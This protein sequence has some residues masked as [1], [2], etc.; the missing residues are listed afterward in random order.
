VHVEDTGPGIPAERL[1]RIFEPFYSTKL[2]SGG[3]GLGLAISYDIVRRH[4]GS[5]GA[6][7]EPGRGTRFTVELPRLARPL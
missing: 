2:A 4:G 6:A 3:T 5:L 7:S 1:A